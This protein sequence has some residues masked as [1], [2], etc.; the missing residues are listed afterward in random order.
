MLV[1]SVSLRQ[2]AVRFRRP[3]LLRLLYS[4]SLSITLICLLILLLRGS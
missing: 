3:L 4:Y 2:G 1:I